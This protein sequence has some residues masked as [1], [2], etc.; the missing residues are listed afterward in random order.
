MKIIINP[1]YNHHFQKII[2]IINNFE[3]TGDLFVGGDRNKIKLFD[4]DSQKINIKFFKIPKFY[5]KIIYR[6]FRDSKAKRSFNFANK[7]VEIQIGTPEPIAFFE[8]Y[9]LVGLAKSYYVCQHMKFDFMFRN[10]VETPELFD[11]ETILRQFAKF[12]YDL[13]E[14]GVEFLDHSPGNTLIKKDDFGNYNFY[15]VDLNRMNFKIYLGFNSRMNN[16]KRLMTKQS[17]IEIFSKEYSKHYTKSE[18]EVFDLLWK[19]TSNFQDNFHRK[20]KMK[21]KLKFWQK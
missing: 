4:L 9:S 5:N 20:Q 7:L 2:T 21:K 8:Q 19:L 3:K 13:H 6:Y 11:V 15:L 18:I 12:C 10:V 1:K 14:K 17:M 16:L